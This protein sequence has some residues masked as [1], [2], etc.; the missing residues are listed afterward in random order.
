MFGRGKKETTQQPTVEPALHINSIPD[1]FYGGNDPVIYQ[2]QTPTIV[3]PAPVVKP[4]PAPQP[5]PA[6]QTAPAVPAPSRKPLYIMLGVAFLAALG[7]ISWY[8]ISQGAAPAP[9]QSGLLEQVPVVVVS[10]S[11]EPQN[12]FD[13]GVVVTSTTSTADDL[14]PSLSRVS[15]DFPSQFLAD[16]AD[17]DSDALTDEEEEIFTT[18]TGTWDTDTDGYYDG[19]EVV[20]LYNPKGFAPVKLIDSGFVQEYVSTEWQYRLYYPS[21]WEIGRVDA[22]GR[23]VLFSSVGGDYVEVRVVDKPTTQTFEAWFATHAASQSFQQLLPITNRFQEEGYKRSDSLVAYFVKEDT[24]VV[25]VYHQGLRETVA[26]RN[27]ME[28]MIQSFRP[29]QTEVELPDQQIIVETSATS[30]ANNTNTESSEVLLP[31]DT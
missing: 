21:V 24:V 3:A 5:K 2:T 8:Y 23:Q 28:M 26:F 1:I 13:S 14:A 4:A 20:N 12:P 9:Q 17:I 6:P 25:L 11:T 27:I 18:D 29:E 15:I 31:S 30:T 19:Q 7:G 10:T 16:A 22:E